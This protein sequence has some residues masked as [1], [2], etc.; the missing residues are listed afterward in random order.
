MSDF[1]DFMGFDPNLNPELVSTL[2]E[3]GYSYEDMKIA[4]EAGRAASRDEVIDADMHYAMQ[5]NYYETLLKRALEMAKIR[6]D[7]LKVTI[8]HGALKRKG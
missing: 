1:N 8:K 5:T 4:Y 7:V 3:G 2:N 6:G